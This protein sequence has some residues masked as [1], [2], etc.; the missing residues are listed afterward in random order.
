MI[1]L[2]KSKNI[3]INSRIRGKMECFLRLGSVE[4]DCITE[5]LSYLGD[6]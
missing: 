2:V 3:Q 6:F 4:I 5:Y 1:N